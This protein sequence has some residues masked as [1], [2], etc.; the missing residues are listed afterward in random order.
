M[1]KLVH[2]ESSLAW[3]GQEIRIFTELGEL[4]KF[5]WSVELW[6]PDHADIFSRARSA[7]MAVEAVPFRGTFDLGS[8]LRVRR[9]IRER[10][11]DLVVTHSSV[12]SWV[13]GFATRC[14]RRRPAIIRTRHLSTSIRNGL[15]YR[16]FPDAVCT[17][18]EAIRQAILRLGVPS[19]RVESIPTGVDLR[20]FQPNPDQ[21]LAMRKKYSLPEDRPLVGGVFV[22]RSWKGIIDFVKIVLAAPNAHFVIAGVGPSRDRMQAEADRLGVLRRMTFLGHVEPVEEIFWA[23]DVFLFPSTANEGVP[24]ALL[25]AQ[26]CGVPSVVSDLP[27]LREASTHALFCPPGAVRMFAEAVDGI[28]GNPE[29]ARRMAED[30]RADA[31]RYDQADAM[32][33]IDRFY[34]RWIRRQ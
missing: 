4:M 13:V 23:L 3:G 28:L 15:S 34:R 26:A 2:T 8:I 24:Q 29:R 16:W 25:Q 22:I 12:D 5:G 17:T 18:S 33:R 27:S 1:L 20:R 11:V 6:A 10:G 21:K 19:D 30:G 9:L 32:R 14:L 7:G 31:R